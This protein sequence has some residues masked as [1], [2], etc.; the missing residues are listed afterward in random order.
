M[1]HLAILST[2][3]HAPSGAVLDEHPIREWAARPDE[4]PHQ[5]L[6]RAVRDLAID[7]PDWEDTSLDPSTPRPRAH[8]GSRIWLRIGWE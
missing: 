4:Q 7:E 2:I 3:L 6:A 1:A 8:L 5:T